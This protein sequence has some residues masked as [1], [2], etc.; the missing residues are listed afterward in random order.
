MGVSEQERVSESPNL[1][2]IV[3]VEVFPNKKHFV[4]VYGLSMLEFRLLQIPL[5]TP[6]QV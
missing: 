3:E 2:C 4:S 1:S 5:P 6:I